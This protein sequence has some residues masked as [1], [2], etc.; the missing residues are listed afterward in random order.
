MLRFIPVVLLPDKS[1]CQYLFETGRALELVGDHPQAEQNFA[2][3]LTL[4]QR[5]PQPATPQHLALVLVGLATS[6][7][8]QQ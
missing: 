7:I 6:L 2:S 4:M 5:T 8:D 3:A 1:K